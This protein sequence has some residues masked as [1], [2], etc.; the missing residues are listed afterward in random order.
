MENLERSEPVL[1][2]TEEYVP[3]VPESLAKPLYRWAAEMLLQD[4]GTP[5]ISDTQIDRMA[6]KNGWSLPQSLN[7]KGRLY[8]FINKQIDLAL[9]EGT[10]KADSAK[11]NLLLFLAQ[12]QA[13]FGDGNARA[14]EVLLRKIA[15]DITRDTGTLRHATLPQ[16]A[17][18]ATLQWMQDSAH[19]PLAQEGKALSENQE[20]MA[21]V[22]RMRLP[23]GPSLLGVAVKAIPNPFP[24]TRQWSAK[25]MAASLL[26][27]MKS[28][29]SRPVPGNAANANDEQPLP[30]MPAGRVEMDEKHPLARLITDA[31]AKTTTDI[32]EGKFNAKK[33]E[34]LRT[35]DLRRTMALRLKEL[36]VESLGKKM[37]SP[38]VRL[39]K[40]SPDYHPHDASPEDKLMEGYFY[41]LLHTINEASQDPSEDGRDP[42]VQKRNNIKKRNYLIHMCHAFEDHSFLHQNRDYLGGT[43]FKYVLNRFKPV[44]AVS[45]LS[46]RDEA[47]EV[48]KHDLA[49]LSDREPYVAPKHDGYYGNYPAPKKEKYDPKTHGPRARNAELRA[50]SFSP[51]TI[52]TMV[53][54][55]MVGLLALL[56]AGYALDPG[57]LRRALGMYVYDPNA[58]VLASDDSASDTPLGNEMKQASAGDDWESRNDYTAATDLKT[59]PSYTPPAEPEE[60]EYKP[61]PV[62]DDAPAYEEPSVDAAPPAIEK[63]V[64]ST[65]QSFTG[66]ALATP[67]APRV[68]VTRVTYQINGEVIS[69]VAPREALQEYEQANSNALNM[70]F[71]DSARGKA[72]GECQDNACRDEIAQQAGVTYS[73]SIPSEWVVS[74]RAAPAPTS[75]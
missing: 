6:R 63:P 15:M 64:I 46:A 10:A 23:N 19:R 42:D 13:G 36:A 39:S 55:S 60:T 66:V 25:G 4:A 38:V 34:A 68:R 71:R 67:P 50:Q 24:K 61:E 14:Q 28:R 53:V 43:N 44:N 20:L 45:P 33:Y 35:S 1:E 32:E 65:R 74:R 59:T 72:W 16:G 30:E 57:F 29:K 9:G 70:I 18:Y 56:S 12:T 62:L 22:A 73:N 58:P 41:T 21:Q 52:G 17:E 5:M 48:R 31:I 51:E 26:A 3:S 49:I 27:T 54:S 47:N 2:L 11:K 69:V 8:V 40:G 75:N 7:H 37:K